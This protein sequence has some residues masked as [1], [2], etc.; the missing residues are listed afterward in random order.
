MVYSPDGS[1]LATTGP[2]GSIKVWNANSGDLVRTFREREHFNGLAF[3]ADSKE[4]GAVNEDK[5]VK[6]FDIASGKKRGETPEL[7]D[8]MENVAFSPNGKLLVVAGRSKICLLDRI[9]LKAVRTI[10]ALLYGSVEFAFTNDSQM[11]VVCSGD[12]TLYSV[13]DGALLRTIHNLKT[14]HVS[15]DDLLYNSA[16]TIAFSPDGRRIACSIRVTEQVADATQP[17]G[18]KHKDHS[19]VKIWNIERD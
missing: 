10:A 14:E 15:R 5:T 13:Q 2:D 19:E 6:L 18:F 8:Y 11:L 3:S 16:E 9:T 1:M 7:F 12:V 17:N 4:I